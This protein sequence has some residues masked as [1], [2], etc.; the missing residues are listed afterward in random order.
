[1]PMA[2]DA[3]IKLKIATVL[4]AAGLKA[5]EEQLDAM[6]A[7]VA[8]TNKKAGVGLDGLEKKIGKLPGAFG[9][10]QDAFG[11]L[12][13]QAAAIVGAATMGLEIGSKIRDKLRELIPAFDDLY[14]ANDRL[15]ESNK[16]LKKAIEDEE[17]A[18][19]AR[20]ASEKES[21]DWEMKAADR[22]IAYINEEAQAYLRAAKARDALRSQGDTA[23][24]NKLAWEEMED[25]MALQANGE[26]EAAEQVKAAYAVLREELKL[27]QEIA[28]FDRESAELMAKRKTD[29]KEV[30]AAERAWEKAEAA[31]AKAERELEEFRNGSEVT[32]SLKEADAHEKKLEK[33]LQAAE[34]RAESRA[35]AME[36][37]RSSKISLF[38]EEDAT[39]AAER[40][41]LLASLGQGRQNAAFAYDQLVAAQGNLTG[42]TFTEEL[43]REIT[44][45]SHES[46]DQLVE[47][48]ENTARLAEKLDALLQLK[49]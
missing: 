36:K 37:A 12:A 7:K 33:A 4:D 46:Y 49:E 30:E 1:M 23:E 22:R 41:N 45:A 40:T 24:M 8:N 21:L 18:F 44:E 43:S 13:G 3:H 14:N 35:L 9:K 39:R 29:V 38:A 5:T 11:G 6:A 25:V 15:V 27:K 16:K 47:I 26:M 17:K 42:T 19:D 32:M 10:L 34:D 2:S 20:L 28:K 31:R 48:Q